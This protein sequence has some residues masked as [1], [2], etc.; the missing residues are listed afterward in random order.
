MDKTLQIEKVKKD[1][2][3]S[4]YTIVSQSVAGGTIAE[5]PVVGDIMARCACEV[6]KRDLL[7]SNFPTEGEG[8][9][10]VGLWLGSISWGV[11]L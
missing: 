9:F 4:F 8:C 7:G 1:T 5:A 3:P 11:D 2:P 10:C 6:E